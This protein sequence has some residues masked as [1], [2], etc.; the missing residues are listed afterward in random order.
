ML[1]S[2]GA[3]FAFIWWILFLVLKNIF[4]EDIQLGS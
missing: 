1:L 3:V 2:M 4:N